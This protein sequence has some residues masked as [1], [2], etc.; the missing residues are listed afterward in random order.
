LQRLI[1]T[2][3]RFGSKADV[4]GAT[5]NV[6]FTP[7]SDRKS[8][9][10]PEGLHTGHPKMKL[11]DLWKVELIRVAGHRTNARSRELQKINA[12]STKGIFLFKKIHWASQQTLRLVRFGPIADKGGCGRVVR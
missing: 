7:N 12:V 4:C 9:H 3:V 5:A 2:Y 10:T 11:F 1:G 6:R 8:G